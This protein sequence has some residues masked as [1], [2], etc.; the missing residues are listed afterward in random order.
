MRRMWPQIQSVDS[1]G[2]MFRF[3]RRDSDYTGRDA[4]SSAAT[5]VSTV[6]RS[7]RLSVCESRCVVQSSNSV[8]SIKT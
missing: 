6:R 5:V 2:G 4:V 1:D 3:D 7:C 8:A